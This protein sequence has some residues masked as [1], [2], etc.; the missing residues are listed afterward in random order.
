MLR[1]VGAVTVDYEGRTQWHQDPVRW[2]RLS[3]WAGSCGSELAPKE[4]GLLRLQRHNDDGSP[5]RITV[6]AVGVGIGMHMHADV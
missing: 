2:L 1:H 5:A 3:L 6:G 4:D